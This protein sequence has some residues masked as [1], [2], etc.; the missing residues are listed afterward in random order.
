MKLYTFDPAPNAQR[1]A[2]FLHYKGI[3][4]DTQ[5]IDMG[6]AEQLS[7][8]Y[9]AINPDCTLP[10]LQLEDGTVLSPVIGI[11][12]YLESVYP[13]RPLMGTDALE[14]AQV[15]G[16]CHKLYNGLMTAVASVLRNSSKAFEN[17]GLPGPQ[18]LPQI[19]ALAERG[20]LQ[21]TH[22]LPA[23]DQE[24]SQRPWL[25]GEHFSFADIDLK[26]ALDFMSWVKQTVPED[27]NHLNGWYLRA[28]AELA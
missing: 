14:R 6:S 12:T 9:R 8:S 23:L 4:L 15:I 16:W 22:L 13:D 1:I 2:L 11:A 27:C 19:P 17:R 7:D 18:D 10:A 26:V 25:A 24:L 28:G 5:Q 20:R 21:L 3:E